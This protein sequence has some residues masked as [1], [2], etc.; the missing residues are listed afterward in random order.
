M[1]QPKPDSYGDGLPSATADQC[2]IRS[3]PTAAQPVTAAEIG[4]A[5][6]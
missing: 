6:V 3:L 1:Q 4:R 5:H 2:P